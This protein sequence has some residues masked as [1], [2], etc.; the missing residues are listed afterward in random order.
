[1]YELLNNYS[2]FVGQFQQINQS[3]FAFVIWS[4]LQLT[5][6]QW[7]ITQRFT[8]RA[9]LF[10]ILTYLAYIPRNGK[11]SCSILQQF[12]GRKCATLFGAVL[13]R[14]PSHRPC[15]LD[16]RRCNVILRVTVKHLAG[17]RQ[18]NGGR[19]EESEGYNCF[20]IVSCVLESK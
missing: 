13:W 16:V 8:A 5:S 14:H 17:F 7:I 15:L 9:D 19:F 4:P 1:M 11:K 2:L 20:N 18:R 10:F 6:K 3:R 12:T